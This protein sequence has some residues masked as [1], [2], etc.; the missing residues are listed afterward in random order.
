LQ[1]AYGYDVEAVVPLNAAAGEVGA[2]MLE[3]S[4]DERSAT[5]LVLAQSLGLP[6]VA[7]PTT[8]TPEMLRALLVRGVEHE[9]RYR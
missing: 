6:F 9:V 5:N 8:L 3:L 1:E 4:L 2:A 7:T